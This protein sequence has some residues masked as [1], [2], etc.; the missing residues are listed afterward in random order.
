MR[1]CGH[2]KK[3]SMRLGCD[4]VESLH[5]LKNQNSNTVGT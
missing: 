3:Q 5:K 4:G 1:V 2:E